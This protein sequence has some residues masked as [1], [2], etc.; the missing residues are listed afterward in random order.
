MED[1]ALLV[2]LDPTAE[3]LL[4]RHLATAKEWFP[5]EF[6]PWSRGRD[7]TPEERWDPEACPM[8]PAVRSALYVNLLTEDN[9][10]YYFHTIDNRFGEDRDSAFRTWNRRWAAEENRHAIVMRD[11]FMVTRALDPVALERARMAQMCQAVV[12]EPDSVG[13]AL[14]YVALQELATRISHRNTG[15]LL[16]D[17]LGYE[18]M[19][20]VA[21]DENLHYL[22]YRDLVTAALEVDP[23][24]MVCAIERQVREFEMPGVGII[25]FAA[26]A[27]AIARAGIYDFVIHHEQILVGVVLRHWKVDEL[28]GLDPAAEEARQS[29]IAH[30][31]RV[32]RVARRFAERRSDAPLVAVH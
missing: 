17:R 7:F 5:H 25:D 22:F 14:A 12:P 3:R 21:A 13:D 15:K 23:S 29:L 6:V 1:R 9:L 26:H 2:T 4:E 11:Y 28:E 27:A 19:A 31:E 8:P 24:G 30:I 32:G 20:R 10:P 16:E 18:V